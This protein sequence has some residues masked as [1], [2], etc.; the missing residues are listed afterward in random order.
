MTAFQLRQHLKRAHDVNM[1]GADW[2]T[3]QSVHSAEHR[4]GIDQDHEHQ[5]GPN[6]AE[7]VRDCADFGC[8][9]ETR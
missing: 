5:D 1:A 9:E 2:G 4:P 3:L 6:P 8:G 7:W